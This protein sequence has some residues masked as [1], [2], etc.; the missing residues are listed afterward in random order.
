MNPD[1]KSQQAAAKR[2]MCTDSCM[3]Y[4]RY[5]CIT[6]YNIVQCVY[7]SIYMCIISPIAAQ[8]KTPVRT[9]LYIISRKRP[10]VIN[11]QSARWSSLKHELKFINFINSVDPVYLL[12][13]FSK[14]LAVIFVYS[15]P[16]GPNP[17]IFTALFCSNI[18][19]THLG[20]MEK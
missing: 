19:P 12:C 7:Y 18:W 3:Y 8:K 10:P 13:P 16:F 20:E 15:A 1:L 17:V 6:V 5:T 2:K 11:C 14:N 9:K 4:I